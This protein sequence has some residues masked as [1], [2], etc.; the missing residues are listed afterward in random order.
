MT[1]DRP[2][3]RGGRYLQYVLA[4]VTAFD[5]VALAVFAS[6]AAAEGRRHGSPA[7]GLAAVLASTPCLVILTVVAVGALVLFVRGRRPI[8]S[9]LVALAALALVEHTQSALSSGHERTFFVGGAALAGWLMGLA[10]A[11]QIPAATAG[12]WDAALAE[13]GAVAGIAAP[14]VEAGLSKLTTSGLFWADATV[15]RSAILSTHPVDDS[16]PLAL[17]ARVVVDNGGVA[18]ALSVAT[19]VIQLGAVAYVVGPRLRMVW[20]ALLLSFHVNVALLSQSI[21]Y[22]QSCVLLMA[23]SFP[24]GR[25]LRKKRPMP[26][27]LALAPDATRAAT[28]RVA[29]WVTV[30]VAAAWLMRSLG[31]LAP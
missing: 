26:P 23:F 27:A 1:S 2:D 11:A 20:G 10:F 8:A 28:L 31:A 14:Y 24:W 18:R 22:V 17:Y 9:G 19:L 5:A 21:F 7:S 30:A 25:I 4:G 3:G 12:A 6:Q 13:A 15:L 29:R 16:S